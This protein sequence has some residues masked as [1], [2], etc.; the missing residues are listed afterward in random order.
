MRTYVLIANCTILHNI[1]VP[2]IQIISIVFYEFGKYFNVLTFYMD[3]A[4][5]SRSSY[6]PGPYVSFI[7]S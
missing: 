2:Q 4:L 1:I 7:S 6:L 3:I 5:V